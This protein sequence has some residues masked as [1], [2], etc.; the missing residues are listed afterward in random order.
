MN[1]GAT[2]KSFRTL[3]GMDQKELAD[4][5]HVSNKTIS[6]WES[7]RTQPKM[8]MIEVMCKVFHCKKS[9]FLSDSSTENTFVL[10][11]KETQLIVDY[12]KADDSAK[13]TIEHILKYAS[14]VKEE[15]PN[16]VQ[17]M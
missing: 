17:E 3:N 10:S 6:S 2:I 11:A 16:E 12:R 4:K 7:N 13:R 5:L 9:D 8:E 14:L 15:L 1:I